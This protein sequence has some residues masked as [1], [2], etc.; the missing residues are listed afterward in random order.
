MPKALD[1]TTSVVPLK[2]TAPACTSPVILKFLLFV[3]CVAVL[4]DVALP[5]SAPVIVPEAVISV[6]EISPS[7][8]NVVVMAGL[9]ESVNVPAIELNNKDAFA[10]PDLN[11]NSLFVAVGEVSF[12]NPSAFTT[13]TSPLKLVWE[14][15][16]VS[17]NSFCSNSPSIVSLP[18]ITSSSSA[19]M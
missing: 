16:L 15:E 17:T 13:K 11:F 2:L 8:V 3:N 9:V 7:T 10:S 14:K 18:W 19:L 5:E 12:V 1:S 6:A 4:A